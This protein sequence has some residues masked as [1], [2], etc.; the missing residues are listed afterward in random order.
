MV[1]VVGSKGQIVI[2]K[3][4]R[5]KL[6]VKPGW[7]ALQYLVDDHI[8]VYFVPPEHNESLAGV[9]APYTDVTVESGKAWDE[10]REQA[11]REA[12]EDSERYL[13]E[14]S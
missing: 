2:T 11:W 14:R 1:H 5:E 3:E 10:A 12:A 8:E 4:I 13:H 9:L 6:G 7:W